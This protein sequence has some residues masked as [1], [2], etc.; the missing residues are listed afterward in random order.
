MTR[1]KLKYTQEQIEEARRLRAQGLSFAR[2]AKVVGFSGKDMVMYHIKR[3]YAKKRNKKQ[4]DWYRRNRQK[5]LVTMRAYS[6]KRRKHA[7]T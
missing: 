6:D 1:T 2:I 4:M 7:R 3:G 5:V